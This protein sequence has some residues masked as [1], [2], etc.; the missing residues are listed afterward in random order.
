M[1]ERHL[2]RLCIL[3]SELFIAI[4]D[5][6]RLQ[7]DTT[8]LYL[9]EFNGDSGSEGKGLVERILVSFFIRARTP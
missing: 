1:D 5:D 2:N 6:A 9:V 3:N 7:K 8:E 4:I